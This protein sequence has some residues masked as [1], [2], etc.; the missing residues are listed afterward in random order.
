M[1]AMATGKGKD[2]LY[3]DSTGGFGAFECLFQL[4]DMKHHQ[5]TACRG[6]TIGREAAAQS[7]VDEARITGAVVDER[8]AEDRMIEGSGP[9]DVVHDELDVIHRCRLGGCRHDG[10]R[11]ERRKSATSAS[12]VRIMV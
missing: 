7:I 9:G 10:S 6:C 12:A 2:R 3:D 8:P 5:R 4:V 1:E 11:G